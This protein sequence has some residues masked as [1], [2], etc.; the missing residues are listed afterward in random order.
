MAV[1]KAS[2]SGQT[3]SPAKAGTVPHADVEAEAPRRVAPRVIQHLSADERVARG[4]GARNETPR[5]SHADWRPAADRRDP[6][7]MLESQAANR[8]PELVPIRNGRMLASP[9]A[10]YRG[11]AYLMAADLAP[12]PRT[13][14]LVQA[15]GDAHLSNFGG[16][17]S[18]ERRLVFDINDFDETLPGPWEWDVKRLSTSFDIAARSRGLSD[19]DRRRAVLTSVQTYREAM[20]QFAGMH[21]L[22][23]WYAH[24]DIDSVLAELQAEL[25]GKLVRKTEKNLEKARSKNSLRAMEKLTHVVDGEPRILADPPLVVPMADL[26]TDV[27]RSAL[28]AE[29]RRILRGYRATLQNDRRKLFERF[30]FVDLARK[31]VGVGSVGTRAWIALMLGRDND[32]PLFLQVKEAQP[33]VL[34]EFL[35]QS[36]AR[37]HGQRVVEGQRLMQATSDILLGWVRV[38]G[39]DGIQ[40]DYYIRQLWDGKASADIENMTPRA[41]ELYARMCG[42]TLA[43]AHAR[44]GD[45]IAIAA[46]LGKGGSFDQAICDFASAYADQ[47]E[48]DYAAFAQAAKSGR[49]VAEEGI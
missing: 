2:S 42:W 27:E 22:D 33:S 49:I 14:L 12:T 6:V 38:R 17:A 34:E 11:A 47:N 37:N 10:F 35:G 4:R 28:V 5:G 48:R 15:C 32:D 31:V 16:Y 30:R 13:G 23:V 26:F 1:K 8:V 41:L 19:K 36:A 24:L 7:E 9:F 40:R 46:Y 43:R 39:V 20:A 3:G 44:S 29:L 21:T 25:K 45:S 18:P